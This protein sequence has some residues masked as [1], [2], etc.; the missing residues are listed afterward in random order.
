VKAPTAGHPLPLGERAGIYRLTALSLRGRGN[1][2]AVG[3][4]L[5]SDEETTPHPG[6]LTQTLYEHVPAAFE[7]RASG[8]VEDTMW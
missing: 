7:A 3:E 2:E 1:R 6:V 4:G 8:F 5:I